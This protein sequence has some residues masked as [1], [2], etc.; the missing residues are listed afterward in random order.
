VDEHVEII[1]EVRYF[2]YRTASPTDRFLSLPRDLTEELEERL[3]RAVGTA[4]DN[5]TVYEITTS[6]GTKVYIMFHDF[7][8]VFGHSVEV[9]DWD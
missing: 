9:G 5:H 7:K 1:G 4:P 6:A 3:S 2:P 8:T